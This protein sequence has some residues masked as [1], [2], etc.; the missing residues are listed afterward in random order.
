VLER[1]TITGNAGHG[2][3]IAPEAEVDLI[4]N[5]LGGN[6]DPQLRDARAKEG[7]P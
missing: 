6:A 7:S 1:N 2:I 3:A 5:Q 4:D